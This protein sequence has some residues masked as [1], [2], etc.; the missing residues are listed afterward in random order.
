VRLHQP[1]AYYGVNSSELGQGTKDTV[2]RSTGMY[3]LSSRAE[4]LAYFDQ[5]MQQRF[6]PRAVCAS[7]R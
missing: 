6:C 7:C 1:V 3:G 5:V 2:S 4:L